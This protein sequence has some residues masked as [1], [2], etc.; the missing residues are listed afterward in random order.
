V[1]KIDELKSKMESSRSK[2]TQRALAA[3][4]FSNVIPADLRL[5]RSQPKVLVMTGLA[6]VVG[7]SAVRRDMAGLPPAMTSDDERRM[8]SDDSV[9]FRHALR[10]ENVRPN[11]VAVPE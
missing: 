8:V 9:A 5:G 4:R 6:P 3:R 1:K 10:N 11:P 2:E 7:T